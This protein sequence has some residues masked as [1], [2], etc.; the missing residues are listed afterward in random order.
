MKTA[1]GHLRANV[2]AYPP[3][4]VA[5]GGTSNTAIGIPR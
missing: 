1:V 2:I 3:L 4:F 5:L